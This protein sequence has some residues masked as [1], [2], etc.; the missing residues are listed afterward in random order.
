MCG[1]TEGCTLCLGP[2]T[3]RGLTKAGLMHLCL[4]LIDNTEA[5]LAMVPHSPS[6]Q[7]SGLKLSPATRTLLA[8][9]QSLSE[10]PHEIRTGTHG[11]SQRGATHGQIQHPHPAHRRLHRNRLF[12]HSHMRVHGLSLGQFSLLQFQSLPYLTSNFSLQDDLGLAL[13]SFSILRHCL[14]ART[15]VAWNW[16]SCS[17][18]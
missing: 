13:L 17:A 16:G 3:L 12:L 1:I 10:G 8:F 5:S 9:L 18:S 2:A 14:S 4:R 15:Q 7:D 6:K 11:L